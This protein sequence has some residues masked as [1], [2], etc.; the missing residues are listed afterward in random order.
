MSCSSTS[1]VP[2]ITYSACCCSETCS[3]QL[4]ETHAPKTV[5]PVYHGTRLLS[6]S[7]LCNLSLNRSAASTTL[8][9][10]LFLVHSTVSI[11]TGNFL[12]IPRW[13]GKLGDRASIDIGASSL[14]F[15]PIRGLDIRPDQGSPTGHSRENTATRFGNRPSLG[16]V[17]ASALESRWL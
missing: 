17:S 7:F 6:S 8:R 16:C 11:S 14:F 3:P 5:T 15:D 12:W 13:F 4:S 1:C 2:G 9:Y 10:H